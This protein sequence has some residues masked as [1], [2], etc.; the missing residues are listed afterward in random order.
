MKN[1]RFLITAF[2]CVAMLVVGVGYALVTDTL[3]ISGTGTIDQTQAE[4]SFREDVYF[5]GVVLNGQVKSEVVAGDNQKYTANIN[6]NNDNKAAF[7]VN[8]LAGAGEFTEITFRIENKGD[9]DAKLYV[10][11]VYNSNQTYFNVQYFVGGVELDVADTQNSFADLAA[12][13]GDVNGSV[14]LVIKITVL[15]TPTVTETLSTIF[16]FDVKAGE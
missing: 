5:S 13:S 3:D 10:K 6:P 1:R 12:K 16:E 8:G 15:E 4:S 9:L 2:L 11:S 7:T 14:D